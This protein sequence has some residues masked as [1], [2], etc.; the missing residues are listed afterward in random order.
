M[1]YIT[2]MAKRKGL[3]L[4]GSPNEV[5]L[6]LAIVV[7]SLIIGLSNPVFFSI[8]TPFDLVRSSL[9]EVLFWSGPPDRFGQ[10]WYRHLV[11]DCGHFCRLHQRRHHADL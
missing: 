11:P 1:S 3:K 4:W 6:V 8:A 7:L 10:R 5:F 9:I 2:P